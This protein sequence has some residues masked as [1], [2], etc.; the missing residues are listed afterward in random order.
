ME[1]SRA[2]LRSRV[3]FDFRKSLSFLC[4]FPPTRGEQ[5]VEG[6][7]FRK[8]FAHDGATIAATVS[9][10][11]E[12][13]SLA[14]TLSSERA[15]SAESRARAVEQV[16]FQLGLDDDLAGFYAVARNDAAFAPLVERLFGQ[17]HVKFSPS[18]FEAAA[19]SILAQR[20]PI[21]QARAV[22][23]SI[24]EHFGGALDLDGE[25][26]RAF[27]EPAA[28]VDAGAAGLVAARVDRERAH[29]IVQAAHA[30][31]DVDRRFLVEGDFTEVERWLR[32]I[33]RIGEWSAAFVLFRALGRMARL[34]DTGPIAR[35]A[36]VLYGVADDR[37]ALA[38]GEAYGQFRGYWAYYLRVGVG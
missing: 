1:H 5:R 31:R 16:A 2:V 6:D 38:R 8:A 4:S 15:L 9:V 27:P 28:I 21:R 37:A 12:P 29:A 34:V 10:G 19:W 36:R 22:K 32:A 3:P 20:R 25:R 11:D 33:P 26:L 17:R 23:D 13:S 7:R 18:P 14:C 35:A 30:F 24:V